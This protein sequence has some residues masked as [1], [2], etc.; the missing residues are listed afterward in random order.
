MALIETILLY[1]L[2][3]VAS[4]V[5]AWTACCLVIAT[6]TWI[7]DVPPRDSWWHHFKDAFMLAF[8]L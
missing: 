1:A 5:L 2:A 8:D 6:F 4:F 7:C 3:V